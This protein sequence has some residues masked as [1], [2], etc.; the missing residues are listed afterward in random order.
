MINLQKI[1]WIRVTFNF[2]IYSINDFKMIEPMIKCNFLP[3]S[4]DNYG[5]VRDFRED[6]R[7]SQYKDK[8]SKKEI[9]Y[10]AEYKGQM[11]GSIWATTNKSEVPTVVRTVM[12]LMPNEGLIH[13]IVTGEKFRGRGVGP[14]M[15]SRF[16]PILL[17]EYKL[18]RIIIDVSIKNRVSL[19]MMEKVGLRKDHLMLYLSALGKL[20]LP[21]VLKKYA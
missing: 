4:I 11:V 8:L 3:I 14:F 5:R 19:R 1:F 15:V 7:I 2:I 12:K 13:D 18:S 20:V 9:G 16:A 21:L 10:F 6:S 17:K